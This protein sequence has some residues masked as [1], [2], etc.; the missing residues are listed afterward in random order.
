MFEIIE[1]RRPMR[2][3]PAVFLDR[4]GVINDD[5]PDFVKCWEEFK[6]SKGVLSS[7]R[8]LAGTPY[9]LVVVTNQSGIGRGVVSD[10]TVRQIHHN[11]VDHIRAT[12]GR[13]DALLYCPHAPQEQCTCRKPSPEMLFMAA[14]ALRLDLSK[15]FM[16]GDRWSD[17][18]AGRRAGCRTILL[19]HGLA[20]DKVEC[21]P[22]LT[23]ENWPQVLA[24][25]LQEYRRE[26]LG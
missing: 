11:M 25:V 12:G 9:A 4:D 18:E 8:V 14:R 19:N 15:S 22:D 21:V 23:A 10:N 26:N 1:N 17:I 5:R 3:R 24:C 13:I 2:S 16:V 6:F 7:L 20:E